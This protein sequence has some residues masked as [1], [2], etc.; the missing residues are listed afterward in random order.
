MDGGGEL[1]T[2]SKLRRHEVHPTPRQKP[3]SGEQENHK[4]SYGQTR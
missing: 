2:H 3:G 4:E 1:H